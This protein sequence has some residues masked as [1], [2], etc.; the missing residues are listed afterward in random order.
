MSNDLN[1]WDDV[2]R[3]ADELELK[4]HLASMDARDRWRE[5]EPRL[6]ELE[7]AIVKSGGETT[8]AIKHELADALAALRTLRDDVVRGA[9]RDYLHGW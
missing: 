2:R 7:H 5:L 6:V 4:I 8:D 3:I 9:R 1:T